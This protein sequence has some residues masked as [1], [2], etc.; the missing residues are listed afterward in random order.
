MFP[1]LAKLFSDFFFVLEISKIKARLKINLTFKMYKNF[2]F[3]YYTNQFQF[4]QMPDLIF[5][6]DPYHSTHSIQTA[7]KKS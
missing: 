6:T 3:V 5:V 4:E 1:N 7:G 2:Q